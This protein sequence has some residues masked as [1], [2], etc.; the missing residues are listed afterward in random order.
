MAQ[1]TVSAQL[2]S[3]ERSIGE[4]LFRKQGRGLVL[5]EVGRTTLNYA[6]E[7]FTLGRDLAQTLSQL[8]TERTPTLRVGLSDA[9]PKLVACVILEP[10]LVP[11]RTVQLV[12]QEG[13]PTE[14]LSDLATHKLDVVIADEPA[15]S[16]TAIRAYSHKLGESTV[17]FVAIP[18]LASQLRDGFPDSLTGAPAVL[19]APHAPLRRAVER[20]FSDSGIDP[21]V[22]AECDDSA[23]ANVL[24]G[25]GVGFAAVPTVVC[26]DVEQTFGLE[27]FGEANAC[28]EQF[29][30]VS[31]ERRL[32][33]PA[34][35]EITSQARTGLFPE[36]S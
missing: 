18:E 19:P 22:C 14:L 33:N 1:P 27:A 28:R 17:S 21:L 10:L 23:F 35:V 5:T 16:G 13:R 36:I 34:V 4:K 2:R 20:W 26:D 30:A 3:L 24:A 9:V 32:K 25:R 7:I 15:P 6:D 12:V 31:I 29:F 11:T 8:P